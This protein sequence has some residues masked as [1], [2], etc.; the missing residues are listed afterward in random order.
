MTDHIRYRLTITTLTPLHVGS[1]Q[2][3]RE[4][5]DFVTH[6]G[7]L[8]IADQGK[9][10]DAMLDEATRRP[11]PRAE[12]PGSMAAALLRA[13]LALQPAAEAPEDLMQF[14]AG[15][16]GK[17]MS[18]FV[19][20][21]WLRDE[22]FDLSKGLF[23][24]AVKGTMATTQQEG[25]LH[26]QIKDVFARAYLP[27]SSLKGALRSMVLRRLAA[28]DSRAPIA[29]G[30][31]KFAAR[32]MEAR[33]FVSE[34][35]PRGA[36]PNYDLWRALH[37]SDSSP[38]A[39]DVLAVAQIHVHRPGGAR[40]TGQG[41]AI[42]IT[43]EAIPSGVETQATAAVDDWLFTDAR[44]AKLGF[45]RERMALFTGDLCGMAN[46]DAMQRIQAE[47]EFYRTAGFT[48]D[49]GNVSARLKQIAEIAEHADAGEMVIQTGR[50]TGWL[51]KT[52]GSVLLTR[53]AAE[54][55]NALVANYNLGRG[56]WRQD[57]PLPATRQ[58][59]SMPGEINV[60]MGWLRIRMEEER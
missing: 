52:L 33:H 5:F 59:V 26:E 44:A 1:G 30:S 3:L 15:L 20:N 60:P 2:R 31:P 50:S 43:V 39:P 4:G 57:R 48:F 42:P 10:Y 45:A 32:D 24:Y 51:S 8:W 9:L 12:P 54:D 23:R 41:D 22:H 28:D 49:T 55:F 58:L 38:I 17:T 47:L 29:S 14:A 34:N 46:H 56:R 21:K 7:S 13:G 53:M 6:A 35:A 11:T 25:E 40:Q 18:Y 36:A 19:A 16:A 27:G 37:V